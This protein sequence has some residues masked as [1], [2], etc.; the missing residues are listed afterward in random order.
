M[1]MSD[2]PLGTTG[3]GRIGGDLARLISTEL[4]DTF[5]VGYAGFGSVWSRSRH[6]PYPL[7]PLQSLDD[8]VQ[9]PRAW[10][11]LAGDDPG[12]LFTIIN[13][14]WLR[15]LAFPEELRDGELKTLLLSGKIKKWAYIPVD[16]V[17]PNDKLIRGEKEIIERMDRILAYTKFGADTIARTL[18]EYPIDHLPHG[19]DS[20]IFHPRSCQEAREAQFMKHIL[21]I[22]GRL[23]EHTLLLGVVA[24][25]TPR[26]D[27]GLAFEILADLKERGIDAGMWAHT[28]REEG[29]WNL[30]ALSEAFNVKAETVITTGNLSHEDMA[31]GYAACNV[32][33]SIGSGEGWGFPGAESLACGVP[34]IHGNYAGQTEYMPFP[35]LVEPCAWRWDGLFCCR[36]PVFLAKDWAD[37]ILVAR[38]M[39]CEL[40]KRFTW[41]GAW[42]GWKKWLTEGSQ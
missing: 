13:P 25:N 32:T 1:I 31:W 24:T 5:R 10:D 7:Y 8:A 30:R 3:L 15:W 21:K 33:L 14:A 28:D 26:K 40:N 9:L 36:R 35:F 18:G 39:Y 17:G 22:K 34:T 2:S 6:L 4:S 27:W 41:E 16:A 42:P 19:I 37:K 23:S 11:D 38:E 20:S 12:I 29:A